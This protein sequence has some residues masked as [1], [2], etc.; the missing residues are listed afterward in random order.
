MMLC[1]ICGNPTHGSAVY[2]KECLRMVERQI[3]EREI[4]NTAGGTGAVKDRGRQ[5]GRRQKH[6][7][8][9]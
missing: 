5:G 3:T 8:D 2:C 4:R 9:K 1:R 6:Q 7:L